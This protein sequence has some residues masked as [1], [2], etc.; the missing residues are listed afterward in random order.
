VK[1]LSVLDRTFANCLWP[2]SFEPRINK[3]MVLFK[4]PVPKALQTIAE[5]K[6]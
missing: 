3:E 6:W 1:K 2:N 4:G 5:P